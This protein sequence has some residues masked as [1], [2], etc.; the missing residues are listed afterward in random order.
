MRTSVLRIRTPEGI[1]FPLILASPVTRCLAWSVD[2]FAII[3]ASSL[4]GKI[5]QV[6][7]VASRDLAGAAA[8]F[9]Y[10][11]ISI[12]YNIV[13]EWYWRG[14]TLGKRL[15]H[16]RVVDERGFNLRFSQVVIRNLLRAV[17][18]LPGFYLVG[19]LACL[20]SRKAQRLGDIAGGTI[21]TRRA[22]TREPDLDQ[23]L[24]GK[25]NSLREHPHLA[26]RLRQKI[27]PREAYLALEALLRRE[28]LEPGRR[29]DL[30][31]DIAGHF[32]SL[33]TFPEKV[34]F[35]L[36]DEQYIRNVVDILF[37]A[38]KPGRAS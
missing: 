7:A 33:V 18:M 30:Y 16:L 22:R 37:R 31:R 8:I 1:V 27:S 10:F 28:E 13:L 4:A 26:G 11:A 12:G 29:V 35:G 24:A 25:Y 5:L 32:R 15:L 6:V 19:G 17:D 36:T 20:V 38:R 23:I 34:I 2:F 14:Q 9:I 21:V 3:V